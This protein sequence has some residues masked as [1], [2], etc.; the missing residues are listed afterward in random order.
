MIKKTKQIPRGKPMGRPKGARNKLGLTA[1]EAIALAAERMGGAERL[2][3]WATESAENERDFWTRI[4]TKLL[5]LQLYGDSGTGIVVEVV[6]YS[7]APLVQPTRLIN[8]NGHFEPET[9]AE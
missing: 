6:R 1:K 3:R 9:P 8:G 2:F 4:Y 7:D 5:P